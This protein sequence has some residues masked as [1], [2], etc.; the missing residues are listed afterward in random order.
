MKFG[1]LISFKDNLFFEG[2]VQADWFYDKEKS[3]LVAESFVFHSKDYFGIDNEKNVNLIDT[4]TFTEEITSRVLSEDNG[5]NLTLAIAGY[6]TGKSH[7]AVTLAQLLSGG[8]YMPSTYDVIKNNIKQFGVSAQNTIHNLD[9]L[10]TKPNLVLVLNG[11]RDFNL[12]AELLKVANKSLHLYGVSDEKLKKVNRTIETAF[13]FMERNGKQHI[14]LLENYA[15]QNAIHLRGDELLTFLADE[16]VSN[17]A[18]FAI[19]NQLYE[20]IN[21]HEIRWDEGISATS[22]LTTLVN[23]Y[24]GIEGEFNKV[25]ILFDEFGRY[26]EYASSVPSGQAGDSAL[27]QIFECIQN[28]E[29]DLHMINFIQSDIKSYLQRVDATSNI[30]RYIGRYEISNKVYLSSNLE[31]IFANLIHRKNAEEFNKIVVRKLEKEEAVDD[32]YRA[33][34]RW[35]DTQGIW[36]NKDKFTKVIVEGIYP[37]HPLATYLLTGLSNYLQNRSSLTMLHEQIEAL[38]DR[39]ISFDNKLPM[40]TA[41]KVLE[42]NLFIELLNAEQEGRQRTT[43]C[44][45][46]ENILRKNDRL[47]DDNLK[48]LRSIL[49]AR[50]LRLNTQSREDVYEAIIYGSGLELTAVI[51]SI[52]I[53]ENEYGLISYDERINVF[54]FTEDSVGAIDFR[55]HFKHLKASKS[56]TFNDFTQSELL[57]IFGLNDVMKTKFDSEN[58]IKTSEFNFNQTFM[59]L[60]DFQESYLTTLIKDYQSS[61]TP[62]KPKGLL[63]WLY[64]N[65]HTENKDIERVKKLSVALERTPIVLMIL[66]DHE[67]KL[68]N[69]LYECKVLTKDMTNENI[70]KFNKFYQDALEKNQH[71]LEQL[72]SEMKN[73]REYLTKQGVYQFNERLVHALTKVLKEIYT[74]PIPFDFDGFEKT[75]I[76]KS[77]KTLTTIFS[78]LLSD[79]VNGNYIQSLPTEVRNRINITL[80]ANG[81]SSWKCIN[82]DFKL[83]QPLHPRV[84]ELYDYYS[85]K[86]ENDK[87]IEMNEIINDLTKPPYGMNIYA[88]IY[89]LGIL[90]SNNSLNIRLFHDKNRLNLANWK[91]VVIKDTKILLE[92]IRKTKILYVEIGEIS[93]KYISL[94]NKIENNRDL[95]LFTNY[96]KQLELLLLE[97]ECPSDLEQRLSVIRFKLEQGLKLSNKVNDIV[98]DYIGKANLYLSDIESLGKMINH[99][100]ISETSL[101]MNIVSDFDGVHYQFPQS[102]LEKITQSKMKMK[103]A[104]DRNAKVWIE[105]VDCDDYKEVDK[106]QSK[107]LNIAKRLDE[108]QLHEEARRLRTRIDEI[109]FDKEGIKERKL[110]KEKLEKYVNTPFNVNTMSQEDLGKAY[111]EGKE[112]DVLFKKYHQMFGQ[113]SNVIKNK[114]ITKANEVS[115]EL[116]R[117]KNE[118][119]KIS[120]D[121]FEIKSKSD[122]TDLQDAIDDLFKRE[123]VV[124]NRINL[125]SYKSVLDLISSGVNELE[126]SMDSLVYF[127]K[128]KESIIKEFDNEDFSSYKMIMDKFILHYSQ[129]I[130]EKEEKWIKDHLIVIDDKLTSKAALLWKETVK[131]IPNYVSLENKK[132]FEGLEAKVDEFLSDYKIEEIIHNFEVLSTVEKEKCF[133]FISEIMKNK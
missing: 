109:V 33:M 104:I 25:I 35:I 94:F 115:R 11:M 53:L 55:N 31:T 59:K 3:K 30:S 37:L 120:N 126:K 46:Y 50:L 95:D 72:V 20:Y 47:S 13:N 19:V 54:D 48:V 34:N 65:K 98:F 105:T 81:M 130:K 23:E 29:G 91:L 9:E 129:V 26:L 83:M 51:D 123:L 57:T 60:E 84:K 16:L 79:N 1:D 73:N 61:I 90:V 41:E 22:I 131:F 40:V 87:E 85:F 36:S 88:A 75:S 111:K 32:V 68:Y 66:N 125:E 39:V 18:A 118:M 58:K 4:V 80:G 116:N 43:H 28:F 10:Q 42:G 112:I 2:A 127:D 69:A 124:K 99:W 70:L 117:L 132:Y 97:N 24:C 52:E 71:V 44:I 100:S 64:I 15:E 121:L 93:T 45:K 17:G 67:N 128:I 102:E 49:M 92:Q 8:E 27:Q 21:G 56:F 106:F 101:L 110:L 5:M 78:M 77:T 119:D 76:T 74:K 6:G 62:D 38:K 89:F 63:V 7:L 86:I 122:L 96:A 107:T 108:M 114:Y 103:S 12:H 133:S 82:A 14:H 113:K